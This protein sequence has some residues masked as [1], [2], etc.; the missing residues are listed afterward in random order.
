M[1]SEKT[2]ADFLISMGK[3]MKQQ[4]KAKKITQYQLAELMDVTPQ[5]ISSAELGQKA[6]RP[7]N[8][9]KMAKILGVSA[10]YLLTGRIFGHRYS[11]SSGQIERLRLRTAS[12]S[13]TNSRRLHPAMHQNRCH[14]TNNTKIRAALA[15]LIFFIFVS[16]QTSPKSHAPQH[17]RSR[18]LCKWTRSKFDC[19]H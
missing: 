13:R 14:F 10:D 18:S 4:R 1:D 12:T 5:M 8:L 7:E 19:L 16:A 9:A 15:A 17:D 3:R 11:P 2:K 6:I